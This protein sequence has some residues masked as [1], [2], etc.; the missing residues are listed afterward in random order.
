M[1]FALS[2]SN[3]E[4]FVVLQGCLR[5]FFSILSTTSV[6]IHAAW[7]PGYERYNLQP[8]ESKKYGY[9]SIHRQPKWP[10]SPGDAIRHVYRCLGT[11]QPCAPAEV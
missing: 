3:L 4:D 5:R 7:K 8:E 11:S 9:H 1:Y 10:S 6:I 2:F